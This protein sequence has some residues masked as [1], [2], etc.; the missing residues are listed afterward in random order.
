MKTQIKLPKAAQYLWQTR[1][2]I[3]AA[4]IVY[5]LM[6]FVKMT[7]WIYL[8]AA[9]I[10]GIAAL[11]IFV[12][13]PFFF[14]SY[15]IEA[16]SN[17][18]IVKHGVILRSTYIMPHPRMIYAYS[19]STPISRRLGLCGIVLKAARGFFIIPD[20]KKSDAKAL[21]AVSVGEEDE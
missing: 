5:L 12:Y 17:A 16:T 4:A 2:F 1:I 11:I 18:I 3:I 19:Y 8:P 15:S 20:M 10:A 9:I 21:F 6:T 7:R 13:I 14:R